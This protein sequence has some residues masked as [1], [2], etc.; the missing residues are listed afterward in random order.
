M[1]T[2]APAAP[3]GAAPKSRK[4]LLI[5]LIVVAV[6]LMAVGGGALYVI[7]AQQASDQEVEDWETDEPRAS[8]RPNRR[9]LNVAPVF[10]ELDL[11][12]VNLADRESDRYLQASISLEVDDAKAAERLKS[13]MP[14]IR[15]SILVTMSYKTSTELLERD[16]KAKLAVELRKEISKALGLEVPE[17]PPARG[18]NARRGEASDDEPPPRRRRLKPEEIT[19][20]KGV[21]FSNFIIQ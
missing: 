1:A 2:A 17:D 5:I 7:K 10:V 16:G 8:A 12:T 21:H 6:L 15:N 18:S 13:F 20:V 3:V 9:D 4:K 14:L 11:F 19:P